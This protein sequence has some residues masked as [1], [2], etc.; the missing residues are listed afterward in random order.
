LGIVVLLSITAIFLI[1]N[2]IKV[3]ILARRREIAIMK[4]VGATN[5]FIRWPFFIEGALLG[6]F[7]S[8]IPIIIILVGYWNLL[9]LDVSNLNLMMIKFKPFNEISYTL[10]VLLLG[11][12]M[13]IGVWGSL[14]SV[15]K[16][17]RV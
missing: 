1:A 5:S 7:G 17:L 8:V 3:T 9:N 2:T 15:R 16:F 4:L 14:L 13:V 10:T 6:F 12:G 11:I